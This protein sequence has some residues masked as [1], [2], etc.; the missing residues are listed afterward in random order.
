MLLYYKLMYIKCALLLLDVKKLFF[1]S[2]L[3]L[4]IQSIKYNSVYILFLFSL[5][6]LTMNPAAFSRGFS[7]R[8]LSQ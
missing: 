8:E 3:C 6:A 5:N 7:T 2:I 4:H 1:I